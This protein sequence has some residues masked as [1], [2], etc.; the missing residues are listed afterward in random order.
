LNFEFV[1]DFDI[2]V[3]DLYDIFSRLE[4]WQCSVY[5]LYFAWTLIGPLKRRPE[6][7]SDVWFGVLLPVGRPSEIIE[8]FFK[9]IP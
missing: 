1:S 8:V 4:I 6:V 3:S 2:R 9:G 5:F 7:F